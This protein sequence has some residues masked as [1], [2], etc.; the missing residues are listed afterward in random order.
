[1][2][3]S[4]MSLISESASLVEGEGDGPTE[5]DPLGRPSAGIQPFLRK[6]C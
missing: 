6:Y 4:S 5:G 3:E 1:M 2:L